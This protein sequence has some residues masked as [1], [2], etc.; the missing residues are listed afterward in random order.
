MASRSEHSRELVRWVASGATV[1]ACYGGV[2]A[3]VLAWHPEPGAPVEAPLT[4]AMIDL[5]PLPPPPQPP[6]PPPPEPPP[7]PMV[8]PEPEPPPPEVKV[9]VAIPPPTRKPPP[10][11]KPPETPPP[12]VPAPTPVTQPAPP[13]PQPTPQVA[14][15]VPRP[16]PEM[17]SLYLRQIVD[18]VEKNLHYPGVSRTRREQGTTTVRLTLDA[19]GKVVAAALQA[20][21]GYR[22]LD[23]EALA[24][25]KRAEPF[26]PFPAELSGDSR[27]FVLPVLFK[28]R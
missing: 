11:V 14:A 19:H 17:L 27:E 13:A 3:G 15:A 1:V 25:I 5:E 2:I 26:P 28:L 9:D 22:A 18:H 16:S 12:P 23:E 4:V 20:R 8:E 7:P 6:A 10:R 24:V 21:S